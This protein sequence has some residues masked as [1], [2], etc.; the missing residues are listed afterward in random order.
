MDKVKSQ[1]V[2]GI[3]R[4]QLPEGVTSQDFVDFLNK[5]PGRKDLEFE[6]VAPEMWTTSGISEEFSDEAY[7]ERMEEDTGDR[8]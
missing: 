7:L 6:D 2:D 1:R 5:E 8:Q 3:F 4:I